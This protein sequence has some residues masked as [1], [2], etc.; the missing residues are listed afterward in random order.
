VD[1]VQEWIDGDLAEGAGT[2]GEWYIIGLSQYKEEYNFSRYRKA[3]EKYVAEN[4]IRSATSRQRVALTFLAV[5]GG[6]DYIAEV[7]SD[8]I[9]ELGIMSYVFGLHMIHNG[10]EC[11]GHSAESVTKAILELELAEGGWA[12]RGE[13]PEAD[14][15]AMVIQALAPYYETNEPVKAAVDRALA[16]LSARQ[17][18]NGCFESYGTANPESAAQVMTALCALGRNPLQEELFIKNGNTKTEVFI[19]SR[20]ISVHPSRI[21]C[22]KGRPAPSR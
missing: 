13:V 6:E 7:A 16:A 4:E 18:P 5:G 8:S 15:T 22:K 2:R 10:V 9:G 3:L 20:L 19:I 11:P 17:L 21:K 12:V 14:T 1:S